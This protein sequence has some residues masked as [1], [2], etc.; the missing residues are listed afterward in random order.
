M[1]STA[2]SWLAMTSG[3]KPRLDKMIMSA[4]QRSN[5]RVVARRM[6]L[7]VTRE[8]AWATSASTS[9]TEFLGFHFLL[10]SLFP[11]QSPRHQRRYD[12]DWVRSRILIE[13]KAMTISSL[14]IC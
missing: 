1:T 5:S 7:F 2:S 14:Q 9:S 6:T 13:K 11:F 8:T 10:M 4:A 12:H 3:P